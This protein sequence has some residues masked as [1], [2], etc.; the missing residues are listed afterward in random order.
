MSNLVIGLIYFLVFLDIVA[1]LGL[2]Y[3]YMTKP[4]ADGDEAD[5]VNSR[6]HWGYLILITIVSVVLWL[7][8]CVNATINGI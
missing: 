8:L 4:Y 5:Y 7:L 6:R 3:N 2:V 1:V